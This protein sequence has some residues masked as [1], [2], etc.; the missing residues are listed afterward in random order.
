VLTNQQ[1]QALLT[2]CTGAGSFVIS[3]PSSLASLKGSFRPY[4]P[5]E[6]DTRR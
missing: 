2:G 5:G 6:F 4:L 3:G 1:Q